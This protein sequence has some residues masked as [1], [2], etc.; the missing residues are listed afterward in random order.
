VDILAIV[1]LNY[2]G[3]SFL[4][5]FLPTVMAHAEGHPVYVADSASTDDSVAFVRNSF[6]LVRVIELPQNDGYAGGYNRSLETHT[7]AVWRGYV[8]RPAQLRH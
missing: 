8:L 6:P 3:R 1:I 4:A 5:D 7:N 2:N